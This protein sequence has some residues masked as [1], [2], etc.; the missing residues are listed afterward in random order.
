MNT[1]L[2][3]R[4]R[5]TRPAFLWSVVTLVV[6]LMVRRFNHGWQLWLTLLPLL[7][8]ML[9]FVALVR[10]I[11]KMDELQKRICFESASIAFVLTLILTFIGAGLDRAQLYHPAWDDVGS[12]M[13]LLF[14][15][16]Y[17]VSVW[18]YR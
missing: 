10:T 3:R 7:P 16:T 1:T 14:A 17:L 18:T 9:F 6:E 2:S 15:G 8:A 13:M 11:R 5:F 4:S 12:L